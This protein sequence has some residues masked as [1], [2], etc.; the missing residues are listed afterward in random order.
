M[1]DFNIMMS[2]PGGAIPIP[3]LKSVSSVVQCPYCGR[4]GPTITEYVSGLMAWLGCIGLTA[5]GC[6]GGCC[7]I[8]F[9]VNSTR[10]VQHRCSSCRQI[11]ATYERL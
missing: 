8:P 3:L 10:D 11:L 6:V 9:C 5:I 7:L 1:P 4:M 2:I